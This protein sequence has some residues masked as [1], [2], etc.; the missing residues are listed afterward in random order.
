VAF[1]AGIGL[2]WVSVRFMHQLGIHAAEMQTSIWFAA[3]ISGV[4]VAGGR[5]ARWPIADQLVATAVVV[6]PGWLLVRSASSQ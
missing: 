6:G 2:Y 1:S 3:T 4:A 5:F